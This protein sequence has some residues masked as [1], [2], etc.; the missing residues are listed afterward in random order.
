MQRAGRGTQALP[1]RGQRLVGLVFG[2]EGQP[3]GRRRRRLPGLVARLPE[4][5]PGRVRLLTGLAGLVVAAVAGIRHGPTPCVVGRARPELLN[6]PEPRGP[7]N[8]RLLG[9]KKADVADD[10]RVVRHVGYSATGPPARPGCPLFSRPTTSI[11]CNLG[12][13]WEVTKAP[14]STQYTATD[15]KGKWIFMP[16]L[17]LYSLEGVPP[18]TGRGGTLPPRA[19]NPLRRY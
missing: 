10:P 15:K 19:T 3:G 1:H 12:A 17:V 5:S 8:P 14:L 11:Q 7:G 2:R 6:C 4:V 18:I 13:G 9:Q 16:A